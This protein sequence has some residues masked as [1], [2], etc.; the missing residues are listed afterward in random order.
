MMQKLCRIA[1]QCAS[2]QCR[3]SGKRNW[4]WSMFT[5]ICPTGYELSIRLDDM[6]VIDIPALQH[7]IQQRDSVWEALIFVQGL[8]LVK[9]LGVAHMPDGLQGLHTNMHKFKVSA[10]ARKAF[11]RHTLVPM[12]LPGFFS[13]CHAAVS[14]LTG[15]ALL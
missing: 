3:N 12:P 10:K 2:V 15:G 1:S 7:V 5:A 6:D 8:A 13:G 14:G 4:A 11:N 9:A